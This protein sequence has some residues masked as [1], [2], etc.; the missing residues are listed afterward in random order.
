MAGQAAFL[1][2]GMIEKSVP[3]KFHP[4]F[5][6][7]VARLKRVHLLEQDSQGLVCFASLRHDVLG[8]VV[9][10]SVEF[11]KKTS[12]STRTSFTKRAPMVPMRHC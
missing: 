11:R 6:G 9:R 5:E 7:V 10:I 8:M 4:G 12:S 2:G 1:L 3:K